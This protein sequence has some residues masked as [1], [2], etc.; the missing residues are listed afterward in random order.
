MKT[1]DIVNAYFHGGK[2]TRTLLMRQPKGGVPDPEWDPTDL[3]LVV[4]LIYGQRDTGRSFRKTIPEWRRTSSFQ[5]C[6]S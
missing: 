4:V 6:T 1:G 5:L 3:M 2:L